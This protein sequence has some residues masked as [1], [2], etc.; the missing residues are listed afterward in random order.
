MKYFAC[1]VKQFIKSIKSDLE[2]E[3]AKA[4]RKKIQEKSEKM[5]LKRSKLSME[6]I[7]CDNSQNKQVSHNVLVGNISKNGDYLTL[8]TIS[9]LQ[10]ILSAYNLK[11][12]KSSKK[13]ELIAVLKEK[14]LSNDFH[15]MPNA[16]VI[17][18]AGL[19]SSGHAGNSS[20]R[21]QKRTSDKV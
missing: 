2:I 12:K 21:G 3:K 20:A 7:K 11:F 9:E 18:N 16:A 19:T 5:S 8:Y 1:R 10:V 15:W 13:F 4:H 14:L 17:T 6:D